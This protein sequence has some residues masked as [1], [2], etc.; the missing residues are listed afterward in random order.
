M[1]KEVLEKMEEKVKLK[2][3]SLIKDHQEKIKSIEDDIETLQYVLD[4][5]NKE[6]IIN[7]KWQIKQ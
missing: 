6:S 5:R 2:I 7:N 3:E 4:H 1:Q